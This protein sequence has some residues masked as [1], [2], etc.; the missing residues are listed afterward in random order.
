[1][2]WNY[3][4]RNAPDNNNWIPGMYINSD[5]DPPAASPE[6]EACIR[7]LKIKLN[8]ERRRYEHDI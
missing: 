1:M 8:I 5:K 7:D 2:R 3:L 4:F 6:I